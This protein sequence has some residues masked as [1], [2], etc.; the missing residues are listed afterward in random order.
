MRARDGTVNFSCHSDSELSASFL[1]SDDASADM[2]S[3]VVEPVIVLNS[4]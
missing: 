3:E 1:I 2:V 4:S